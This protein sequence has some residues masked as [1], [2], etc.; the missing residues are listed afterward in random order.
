MMRHLLHMLILRLMLKVVTRT[1]LVMTV[2]MMMVVTMLMKTRRKRRMKI[3]AIMGQC[4]TNTPL[5]MRMGSFAFS[6]G[7]FY[8]TW[9]IP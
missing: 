3:L 4:I 5:K 9:V 1:I 7:K 8:S 2:E 6:C